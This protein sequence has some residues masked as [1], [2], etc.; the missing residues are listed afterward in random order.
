[1]IGPEL[2]LFIGAVRRLGGRQ[3]SRMR[4]Q[5]KVPMYQTD[6]AGV[7][8]SELFE[9]RHA[10]P[11]RGTFEVCIFDDRDRSGHGP[12]DGSFP[13]ERWSTGGSAGEIHE[14]VGVRDK[15]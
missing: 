7:Q 14:T 6:L 11:A 13:S 8:V 3:G 1:M 2:F 15:R 9:N 10:L 5:R 4:R 12:S